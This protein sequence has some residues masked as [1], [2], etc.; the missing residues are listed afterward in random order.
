MDYAVTCSAK[1][2]NNFDMSLM[3]NAKVAQTFLKLI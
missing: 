1:A 3:S 2:D